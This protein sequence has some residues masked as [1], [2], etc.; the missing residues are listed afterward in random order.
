MAVNG[1]DVIGKRVA[2]AVRPDQLRHFGRRCRRHVGL[3][4]PSPTVC[5]QSP[6]PAVAG[7]YAGLLGEVDVV[8]D[9]PPTGA[10]ADNKSVYDERILHGREGHE[11]GVY[12][13]MRGH[14]EAIA[15]P[16]GLDRDQGS[17]GVSGGTARARSSGRVARWGPRRDGAA[18]RAA[19]ASAGT[20]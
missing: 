1:Y 14:N 20:A 18:P 9:C 15:I 16:A 7:R 13:T 3:V 19:T 12:L 17:G 2:D 8:V 6:V 4:R 5:R 11:L 10:C